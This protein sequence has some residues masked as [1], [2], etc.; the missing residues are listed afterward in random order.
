[1]DLQL[2][3]DQENTLEL[4]N[5]QFKMLVNSGE[6]MADF[7]SAK[8]Y[9]FKDDFSRLFLS[10]DSSLSDFF[11]EF[12]PEDDI[13]KF[14]QNAYLTNFFPKTGKIKL[15]PNFNQPLGNLLLNNKHQI[16]DIIQIK[17]ERFS[18]EQKIFTDVLNKNSLDKLLSTGDFKGQIT[19]CECG[20]KGCSSQYLWAN[21]SIG[22]ISFH[23]LA[24][25]FVSVCLYPF[26]LV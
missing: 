11:F 17:K 14:I 1:M 20:E 12:D 10:Y 26:K 8:D 13:N 25:K 19:C 4:T 18:S 5:E 7:F 2:I 24:A 3:F 9:Y 22:M 23:I 16:N 6:T 15:I 21:D